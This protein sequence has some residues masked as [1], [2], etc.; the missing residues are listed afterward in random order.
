MKRANAAKAMA[1]ATMSDGV[2]GRPNVV[3]ETRRKSMTT[4]VMKMAGMSVNQ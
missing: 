4:T 2:Y 3:G 1:I